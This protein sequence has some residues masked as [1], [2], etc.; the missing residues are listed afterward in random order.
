MSSVALVAPQIL[1][2]AFVSAEGFKQALETH[3]AYTWVTID[4]IRT[5]F[6][7]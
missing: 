2:V 7:L 1:H 3:R 5:D 6:Y 4:C